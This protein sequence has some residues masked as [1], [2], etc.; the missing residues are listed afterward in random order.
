MAVEFFLLAFF[1]ALFFLIIIVRIVEPAYVL[2]FNKPLYL[3]WYPIPKKLKSGQRKILTNNFSFYNRLSA[4]RKVYFEHRV[5][6]FVDYYQFIGKGNLEVTDEMKMLISGTYVML[7]FGMR[8]YLVDLFKK[9]IIYPTQYYSTITNENHKGEYNP[10]M[11]AVV[12]SW[13]DFLSG[14]QSTNDNINLGLHEFSH[15]LHFHCMKSNDSSAVIFFDEFNEI[16][17]YYQDIKLN[18]ALTEKGYFRAYAFENQFEFLSVIIES[19][20]ETPDSFRKEFPRLFD[21]V[22]KMLNHTH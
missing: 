16:V 5:K 9:I 22:S 12:F 11:K 21:N 20:F 3:Y 1:G 17:K 13:E 8:N 2:I 14:H 19:Y 18:K 10:R 4:K 15:V 6:S 7:T